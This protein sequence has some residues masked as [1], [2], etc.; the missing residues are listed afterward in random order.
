M[1]DE[2]FVAYIDILGF[3]NIVLDKKNNSALSKL[4]GFHKLIYDLWE[5]MEFSY[6]KEI[7]GLAF[8]DSLIIYSKDTSSKSLE[9]VLKFIIKLYDESLFKQE[10][11]LR[12]GLAKGHFKA[13]E[14]IGFQNLNKKQFYG[15]AFIDAYKLENGSGVKGCR[16]VLKN[17][18]INLIDQLD[19]NITENYII[20]DFEKNN[21]KI[22]DLLWID[23]KKLCE[24]NCR[25]LNAFYKLAEQ[26]NWS[27]HYTRTLDLF[28]LISDID[29]YDIIKQKIKES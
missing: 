26:Y 25:R 9:N 15:K 5:E 21:S 12:G 17:Y 23:K 19:N 29:K 22:F 6:S 20:R 18:I 3:K 10:L 7:N 27:D 24:D 14:T 28:C 8:S 2:K 1:I 16:F 4:Q 13:I 11:M